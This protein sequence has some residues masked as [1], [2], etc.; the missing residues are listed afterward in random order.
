M[1]AHNIA[2]DL[3]L[4]GKQRKKSV[5]SDGMDFYIYVYIYSTIKLK[6]AIQFALGD[7]PM[8]FVA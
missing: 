2:S 5:A 1:S 6:D 4:S 7:A 3:I 8:L